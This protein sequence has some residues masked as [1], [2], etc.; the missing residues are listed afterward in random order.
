MNTTVIDKTERRPQT[1]YI[2][3]SLR[4]SSFISKNKIAPPAA[5]VSHARMSDYY[6]F[7]YG[8][9][10]IRVG[11]VVEKNVY[12]LRIGSYTTLG[13]IRLVNTVFCDY[14][15]FYLLL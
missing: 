4:S 12:L 3:L 6:I 8:R 9:F 7:S 15:F 10:Q 5:L 2:V 11:W 13:L 1:I 14:I